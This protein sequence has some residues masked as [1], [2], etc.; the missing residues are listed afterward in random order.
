MGFVVMNA[1][2]P[3]PARRPS[4]GSELVPHSNTLS[5]SYWGVPAERTLVDTRASRA[6]CRPLAA[7]A[8]DSLGSYSEDFTKLNVLLAS[9]N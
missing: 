3:G 9:S 2:R 1:V 6:L 4:G 8:E 5:F 7:W